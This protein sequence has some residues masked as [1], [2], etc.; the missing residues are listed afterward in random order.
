MGHGIEERS[1]TGLERVTVIKASEIPTREPNPTRDSRASNFQNSPFLFP[2]PPIYRDPSL[3]FC[4]SA[5]DENYGLHLALSVI[6]LG[7]DFPGPFR[8][9][10]GRTLFSFVFLFTFGVGLI[11]LLLFF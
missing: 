8:K 9:S 3:F 7:P 6:Y 10:K 5:H 1:E 2:T 4:F 11:L